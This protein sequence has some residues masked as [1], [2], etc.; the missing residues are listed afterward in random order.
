MQKSTQLSMAWADKYEAAKL[1]GLR[2]PD[3]LA[4]WRNP[5][6]PIYKGWIEGIHW[7]PGPSKTAPTQYSLTALSHWRETNGDARHQA[8]VLSVQSSKS[9]SLGL[10]SKSA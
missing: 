3:T 8:W 2:S 4:R 7:R 6:S 9:S 5:A 10:S 1:L